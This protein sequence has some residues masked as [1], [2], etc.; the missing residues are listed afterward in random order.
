MSEARAD[1]CVDHCTSS[2]RIHCTRTGRPIRLREQHRLLFCARYRRCST[3]R[4]VL[5]PAQA[6]GITTLSTGTLTTHCNAFAEELRILRVCVDGHGTV[7][8]R[9]GHC[10][11]RSDWRALQIR[12]LV[13]RRVGLR[14]IRVHQAAS[15]LLVAL[16]VTGSD[17]QSIFSRGRSNSL[18]WPGSPFQEVQAVESCHVPGGAEWRHPTRWA[19]LPPRNC[20]WTIK[21]LPRNFLTSRLPALTSVEPS[22]GGTNDVAMPQRARNAGRRWPTGSRP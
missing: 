13:T 12:H 15:P 4:S 17:V 19:R 16:F 10:H 9:V 8:T 18:S 21:R 20:A 5:I 14:S 11:C 2:A 7:C 22:V 3:C 1:D 6:S